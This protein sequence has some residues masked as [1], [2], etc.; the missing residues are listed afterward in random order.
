MHFGEASR[1]PSLPVLSKEANPKGRKKGSRQQCLWDGSPAPLTLTLRKE[2]AGGT[3][4][5]LILHLQP[6]PLTLCPAL[7][8]GADLWGPHSHHLTLLLPG[9]SGSI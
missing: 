2:E 5:V 9:G 7:C 4:A 6:P 3:L 8:L 1:A